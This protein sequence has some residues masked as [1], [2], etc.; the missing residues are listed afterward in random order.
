MTIVGVTAEGV[1]VVG[2]GVD[3]AGASVTGTVTSCACA[4][5][6]ESISMAEIA[7]VLRG[8]MVWNLVMSGKRDEM[9]F[10]FAIVDESSHSC[11]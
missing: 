11:L 2:A 5:P 10:G 4:I 3:T 1:G 6:A 9:R 8:D 7:M